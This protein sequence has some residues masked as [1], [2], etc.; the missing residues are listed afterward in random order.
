MTLILLQPD[1]LPATEAEL[2]AAPTAPGHHRLALQL[3]GRA[4]PGDTLERLRVLPHM[5]H[6]TAVPGV[7]AIAVSGDVAYSY[8]ASMLEYDTFFGVSRADPAADG[9]LAQSLLV[10]YRSLLEDGLACGTRMSWA[11]W[12]ALCGTFH[13]M[14][15]FVAGTGYRPGGLPVAEPPLLRV[16]SDPRRR[17]RIGHHVFFVLTQSLIVA[18]GC[19]RDA[20]AEGDTERARRMLR[21]ATRLLTGSAAAF[22]FAGEFSAGQYHQRVRPSMEPPAVSAGFSGLLSPD[23]HYLVRL[24]GRLRPD[25]RG[26]PPE[27]VAEYRGFLAALG[28]VY[29]SHKYACARF[30]GDRGASL[31]MSATSTVAAVDVIQGLKMARTKLVRLP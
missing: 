7:R 4:G 31:R 16:H 2:H 1:R 11:Q 15:G 5:L 6:G 27:L 9:V 30:G 26:L 17:W 12:S 29:E 13:A 10:A 28:Q 24:F 19:F 8:S 23:H 20:R 3:A 25:L 18:L 14:I 22:V 21:L